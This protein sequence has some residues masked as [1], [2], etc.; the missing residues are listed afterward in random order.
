MSSYLSVRRG[1][2]RSG[3]AFH[4]GIEIVEA[5]FHGN[6]CNFRSNA[7]L[8]PA[9]LDTDKPI[10]LLDGLGD[11]VA[12]NGSDCAQVDNLTADSLLCER[13]GSLE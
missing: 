11:R 13:I 5:I 1:N 10:R 8:W 9:L 2:V 7:A 12:V 3:N 4:R 6:G